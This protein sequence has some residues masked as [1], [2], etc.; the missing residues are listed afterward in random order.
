MAVYSEQ[1]VLVAP[2]HSVGIWGWCRANL[3]SSPLNSALTLGL[4]Y[5]LLPPLWQLLQW[6]FIRADWMGAD[7]TA[8]TSGGACWVFI[9]VRFSQFIYGFYP[10]AERW[11]VDLMFALCALQM[12]AL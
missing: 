12:A 8:C 5:L 7:R 3:F 1:P 2:H 11:R 10:D 9:N 6:A 4:L